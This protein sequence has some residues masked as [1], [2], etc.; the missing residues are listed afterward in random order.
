MDTECDVVANMLCNKHA[1]VECLRS[2][3]CHNVIT[4]NEVN[5]NFLCGQ[6]NVWKCGV[7]VQTDNY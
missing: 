6:E 1:Y 2:S 3:A 5:M 4:G 7:F